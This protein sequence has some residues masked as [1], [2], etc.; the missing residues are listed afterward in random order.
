[1]TKHTIDEIMQI[2]Y[3]IDEFFAELAEKYKIVINLND[4]EWS[5]E[6]ER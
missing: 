3:E 2:D 1:M 4:L 5:F 6:D